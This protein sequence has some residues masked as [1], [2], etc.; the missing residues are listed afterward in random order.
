MP[1]GKVG[2]S[3]APG[4]RARFVC[5]MTA[6]SIGRALPALLCCAAACGRPLRAPRVPAPEPPRPGYALIW[7][8]EFDGTA[9]D[10][11][12]WTAYAGARRDARNSP[13]AIAVAGGIV[14]ITTWTEGGVHFTG[15]FDTAGKF[16]TT[17]GWFEARIRFESAPGEWGAFWLSSPTIGRPVGD[18]GTAGTEID[19][20]EHR[21]TDTSGAD[22]SNSYG[23]NLHWDG[24]GTD[25][26]HAGG[27][28]A[29]PAGAASLQGGWHTY[30]MLWTR[31]GYTFF[32]DGV[33]QWTTS[34]G[35]SRRPEFIKLTC[36]VQDRSWAGRVPVGGYGPRDRST[37]RMQVDWIRVWQ[38]TTP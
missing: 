29:P 6:R 30:A 23:I 25:H 15:F 21:A 10:P 4:R 3:L 12:R 27:H 33:E 38:E 34:A 24:Y 2:R 5:R 14:T 18:P 19:V 32:L 8:D 16:L 7:H 11:T 31:A 35:L 1:L 22:I 9:L 17:Y 36:E 37:T 20:V 26:K 13:D 28:G